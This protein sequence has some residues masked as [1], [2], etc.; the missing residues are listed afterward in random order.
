MIIFISINRFEMCIY[1]DRV[2]ITVYAS[3]IFVNLPEQFF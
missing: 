3:D 1:E 2:V